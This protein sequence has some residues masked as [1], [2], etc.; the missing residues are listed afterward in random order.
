[1]VPV[2]EI[3]HLVDHL[4]LFQSA[5]AYGG[6]HGIPVPEPV[7]PHNRACVVIL[8]QL[9]K[10]HAPGLAI[11]VQQL[12]ALDDIVFLQLALEPLVDLVLG[13]G[14][15]HHVQPVPAGAL[16]ILGS[17]DLYPVPVL[18][19]I[20][21]GHQLVVHPGAHHLVAHRG[22]D[23][24]GKIDCRGACGQVL[25]LPGGREAVYIVGKQIQVV[26]QKLHELTVVRHVPLP[27]QN[28]AQPA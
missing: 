24:V 1:M 9:G 4:A 13:L 11:T 28:L 16:G 6:Q 2:I 21:D 22:M 19:F 14:A 10:V 5:V 20:I 26:L 7:F 27:F 15:L 18:D 25:H 23:A 17:D 3:L 12:L 8:Q